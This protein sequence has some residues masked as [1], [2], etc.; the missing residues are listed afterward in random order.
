MARQLLEYKG[1]MPKPAPSVD[2][3]LRIAPSV[4]I[5][6]PGVHFQPSRRQSLV[7]WADKAVMDGCTWRQQTLDGKDFQGANLRD[8]T[9]EG[10]SLAACDFSGADLRGARF[11]DCDMRRANLEHAKLAGAVFSHTWLTGAQGLTAFE[12]TRLRRAGARFLMLV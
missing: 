9:F 8:A 6:A 5:P 4:G 12:R 2:P 1:V 11:I 10:C 7:A 3:S